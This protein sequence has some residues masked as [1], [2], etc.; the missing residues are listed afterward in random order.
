MT[1]NAALTPTER[2]TLLLLAV[3]AMAERLSVDADAAE[4]AI[5]R[6]QVRLHGGDRDAMVDVAGQRLV[7]APR[8]WL[9]ELG[10]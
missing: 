6:Y 5:D 1:A 2:R 4:L 10:G 8:A 3:G 7:R 9:A